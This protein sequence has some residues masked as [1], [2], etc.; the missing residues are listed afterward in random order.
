MKDLVETYGVNFNLDN[1]DIHPSRFCFTCYVGVLN[2]KKRV[3]APV[4]KI[5]SNW[6]PHSK[7]SSTCE[8][9]VV[10]SKGGRPAKRENILVLVDPS[11]LLISGML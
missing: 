5:V 3:T 10:K 1:P 9:R 6:E 2:F 8:I 11:L 7:I 4:R